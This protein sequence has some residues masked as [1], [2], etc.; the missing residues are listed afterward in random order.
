MVVLGGSLDGT[1]STVRGL[2]DANDGQ[3]VGSTN[4][5]AHADVK[6]RLEISSG[7]PLG[8][9]LRKGFLAGGRFTEIGLHSN[10]NTREDIEFLHQ[11]QATI[12]PL[13]HVQQ[14]GMALYASRAL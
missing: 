2:F 10:L 6:D 7:T 9:L 4:V 12:V 1:Y 5:D 8:R 3:P 11:Q 14:D 13:A